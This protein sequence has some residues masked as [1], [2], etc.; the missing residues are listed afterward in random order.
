MSNSLL[1][2][3]EDYWKKIMINIPLILT[4]E[5]QIKHDMSQGAHILEQIT[6]K[7]TYNSWKI[8][9]EIENKNG[10]IK[11]IDNKEHTNYYRS[12]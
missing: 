5:S 6:K 10:L 7:M 3:D 4:E 11:L 8:F 9:K 2:S 12:K 1:D